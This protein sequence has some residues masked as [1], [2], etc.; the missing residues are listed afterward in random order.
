MI[1]SANA[2]VLLIHPYWPIFANDKNE[3][4]A[5]FGVDEYII[6]KYNSINQLNIVNDY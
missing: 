6:I 5:L 4:K 2:N 1:G 3:Y